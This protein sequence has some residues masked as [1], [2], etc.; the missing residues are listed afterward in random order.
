MAEI[1]SG[2]RH[3]LAK[4]TVHDLFQHLV[5]AYAWRRK[6]ISHFVNPVIREGDKVIDIGCGTGELLRY[7][8]SSISYY[9]FDRNPDYIESARK[10][11]SGR[12]ATFECKSVGHDI[13]SEYPKFDIALAIGLM[14]HLDDSD[15]AM[16]LR[17]ARDILSE[18]GYLFLLDPTFTPGQSSLSRFVVGKDRGQNVR[19]PEEY[20]RLCAEV[21]PE[22]QC[23]VDMKPLWIPYA[24]VVIRCSSA[25]LPEVKCGGDRGELP[26][27]CSPRI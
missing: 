7:L 24:G 26:K 18:S 25:K 20:I 16:M 3:V 21:F 22:T 12:D 8:P 9:G 4:P 17:S 23:N 15:A 10:H 13:G 19:T 11:F 5:G 27:Y 14:H 1:R 6:F 2:L